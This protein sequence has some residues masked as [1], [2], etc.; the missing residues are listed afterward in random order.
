[1]NFWDKT[2]PLSATA[3]ALYDKLIPS[4]GSCSTLQGEL[5][6]ASSKIGY[7]WYNN[8]WGCNNWSGAVCFLQ[9][10]A[11]R[12][13]AKRTPAEITAFEDALMRVSYY[14]HGESMGRTNEWADKQVTIIHAFVV[15]C[16]I[17]NPVAIENTLDMWDWQEPDASQES[18]EDDGDD[19]ETYN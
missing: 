17:D 14:S 9:E 1:M 16:L 5:L 8:G 2:H 4:S 10:H 13:S 6:R 18:E 7:D 15:Q 12:L 19:E 11:A 3:D